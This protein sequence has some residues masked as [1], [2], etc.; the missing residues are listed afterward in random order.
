M[1]RD[2]TVAVVACVT[3]AGL[4]LF[5]G[6]RTWQTFTRVRPAPLPPLPEA[7]TGSALLPWLTAV[8]LVALAGAGALVA[9]RGTLRA[10]VGG[11]LVLAGGGVVA[12]AVIR[13]TVG[14]PLVTALGGALV[15]GAGA[16]TLVRGG[17][18]PGMAA[19]YERSTR[20]VGTPTT[21][22]QAWDMLDRGHDPT[23]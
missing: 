19:R 10:A 13:F 8:G 1:S 5:A 22:A 16:L 21:D 23:G 18:W 20:P 14:W 17:R 11:L 3:G 12:G 15:A 9:T 4:A 2:R 6:S 7:R